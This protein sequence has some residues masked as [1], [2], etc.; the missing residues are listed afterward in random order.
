MPVQ[1]TRSIRP[2]SPIVAMVGG[3]SI[4]MEEFWPSL[5]ELGGVTTMQDIKLR[6]ALEAML[7]ERDIQITSND[8]IGERALLATTLPNV[9]QREFDDMLESRGF[10][11]HRRYQLLWR[12]AA[13]RILVAD[14]VMVTQEAVWR[15]YAIIHGPSY[16]AK[17]IVV[18]TLDEAS[19]IKSKL[20]LGASFSQLA[21]TTSIDPSAVR[22]G[23]VDSISLADPAWP[24]PIRNALPALGIGE[25]SDPILIGN[26]WI[27]I[28][29]TSGPLK[30][31]ILFEEV[32]N[33]M[34]N[35]ATLAQERF[36]MEKLAV[37][38]RNQSAPVLF[39]PELQR[40]LGS[41]TNNSH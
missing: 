5:V 1:E 35:L 4:R 24:S 33:E 8:I 16:S 18:T 14:D 9:E 29:V 38:L 17:V 10:G 41:N 19:A 32:E 31:E 39:D 40:V 7:D 26:R 25:L 23:V 11:E 21:E 12:N 6:I 13:L 36:L 30:S 28:T 3:K 20:A 15:M 22:C 27:L 2:T 37:S 34:R